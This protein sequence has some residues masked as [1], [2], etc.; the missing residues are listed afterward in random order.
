VDPSQ[1]AIAMGQVQRLHPAVDKLVEQVRGLSFGASRSE[2][3][4]VPCFCGA[5]CLAL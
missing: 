1:E 2:R 3:N 5:A 4:E